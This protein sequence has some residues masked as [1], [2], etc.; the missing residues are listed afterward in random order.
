MTLTVSVVLC[1]YNGEAYLGEQLDSLLSQTRLPDEVVIGD[2]GSTDATPALLES[3]TVRAKQLGIVVQLVH[4]SHNLGFIGNFSET[5]R[6]ANGDLLF[7]CD[8]DDVW[9]PGKLATMEQ[10][11]DEDPDLLMLCTDAQLIGARGE[12]L[13]VT[14]FGALELKSWEL[15][16]VHGN[17]AFGVLLRRSMVTGATAGLRKTLVSSALPVGPGWIH[18]EWLAIVASSM[19]RMDA[20]EESWIKYRQH[21]HNQIGMRKRGALDKWRDLVRPRRAQFEA[22]LVRLAALQAQLERSGAVA[23]LAELA[24]KSGHFRIRVALGRRSRLLRWPLVMREARAG[25]YRRYGTGMRSVL[26]DLL[27]HD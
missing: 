19:G 27:R 5:M 22:E 7:L 1:T 6:L 16:Q 10:R 25:N 9:L 13:G 20:L 18:D 26:R 11:F 21:T 24:R 8:Q 12:D 2:D 3:F 17:C 23:Q 4:R 15:A 14:L